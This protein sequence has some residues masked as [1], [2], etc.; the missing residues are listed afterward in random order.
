MFP[1]HNRLPCSKICIR[2]LSFKYLKELVMSLSGTQEEVSSIV[3]LIE[4]GR[5]LRHL[6][7]FLSLDKNSDCPPSYMLFYPSSL[8]KLELFCKLSKKIYIACEVNFNKHLISQNTNL[9]ELKISVSCAY[10]DTILLS[11]ALANTSKLRSLIT[12]HYNDPLLIT[13]AASSKLHRLIALQYLEELSITINGTEKEISSILQL[14]QPAGRQ[15]R[16]LRLT[17]V[18]YGTSPP[19][20]ML[21]YPSSLEKLEL[22][23]YDHVN[24]KTI[25]LCDLSFDKNLISQN[26]NLKE[27]LITTSCPCI[28]M[29]SSLLIKTK[30]STR[31]YFKMPNRDI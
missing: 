16:Y 14:I 17:L 5:P 1:E 2:L 3:P 28:K 15:L 26:T 30:I 8:E 24:A 22:L 18:S 12:Y 21:L 25:F 13:S 11:L 31:S 6:Q 20:H 7:L 27:L 19:I 29:F 9:K 23:C 10:W 4:S